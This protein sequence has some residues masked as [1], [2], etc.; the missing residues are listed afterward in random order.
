[1]DK[2]QD[3]LKKVLR[4]KKKLLL[5]IV[6]NCETPSGRKFYTDELGKYVNVTKYGKCF[7]NECNRECYHR[8]M[9]MGKILVKIEKKSF[10][11]N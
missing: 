6:S 4:H 8:E 11:R 10:F 1:M 2:N 3:Q 9:S 5:Q 7:G